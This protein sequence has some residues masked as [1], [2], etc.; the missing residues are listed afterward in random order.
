MK[1]F[2][3]MFCVVSFVFLG[4]FGANCF[5]GYIF[6]IK[7]QEEIF[8]AS[9]EFGV[10]ETIIYSIINTE[11]HFEKDAKSSKGAVG[12]MQLMP[13]T[14]VELAGKD[15]DF[16]E[17]GTNINLGT[18]YIS[19]LISRFEILETAVAA[20]N[21]G[22]TNVKNWLSDNRYSDDGKILKK[23]PFEETKG[24]VEK[25]QKNYRYYKIKLK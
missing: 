21:A 16:K 6:P 9:K 23:I 20:Y 10:E 3:S 1:W 17:V 11:S 15:C 7:Y 19:Q 25:F 22:P 8:S 4:V 18:K 14:A 2:I 24:Y 12:L 5:Y 13:S